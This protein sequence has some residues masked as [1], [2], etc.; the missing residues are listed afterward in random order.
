MR[1]IFII[2]LVILAFLLTTAFRFLGDAPA[3]TVD[4]LKWIVYA[5][6]FAVIVSWV[7]ERWPLYQTWSSTARSAFQYGAAAILSLGGYALLTYVPPSVW[8]FIDPWVKVLLGMSAVW[9]AGQVA[10]TVDPQRIKNAAD[11][12]AETPAPVEV[13]RP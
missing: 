12:V 9:G 1:K 10:H 2:A 7:C 11:V 3:G 5:G 13:V 6:G 8:A 4:I